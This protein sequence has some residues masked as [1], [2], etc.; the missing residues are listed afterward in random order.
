VT[1]RAV[2]A[3]PMLIL[4][5]CG[6]STSSD[7]PTTNGST[8][9]ASLSSADASVSSP[10]DAASDGLRAGVAAA[11]PNGTGT[12]DQEISE[13]PSALVSPVDSLVS[14]MGVP[15]EF[16]RGVVVSSTDGQQVTCIFGLPDDLDEVNGMNDWQ[17][18]VR[19]GA[20]ADPRQNALD[21]G[22]P[23]DWK[24]SGDGQYV[25]VSNDETH[26]ALLWYQEDLQI[27][28]VVSEFSDTVECADIAAN[29]VENI[30]EVIGELSKLEVKA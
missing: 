15:L 28:F 7:G 8:D 18:D 2:L 26:C 12:S 13:C 20:F 29:L 22:W 9:G 10:I 5:A 17:L 25:T 27:N 23:S 3:I 16:H 24:A 6:S 4:L 1:G 21:N 11:V 30:G 14:L 19:A